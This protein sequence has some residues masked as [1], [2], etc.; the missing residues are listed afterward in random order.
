[1]FPN[2]GA[3]LMWLQ[4]IAVLGAI[5]AITFVLRVSCGPM[6]RLVQWMFGYTPGQEPSEVVAGIAYGARILAWS[7]L[8]FAIWFFFLRS[9]TW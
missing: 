4:I 8:M 1:M 6:L 9:R 3:I 2:L 7:G 5:A